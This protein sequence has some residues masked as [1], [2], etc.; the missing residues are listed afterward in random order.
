MDNKIN[1]IIE[2][3]KK[4]EYFPKVHLKISNEYLDI[5]KKTNDFKNYSKAIFNNRK[6]QNRFKKIIILESIKL[7][8]SILMIIAIF[9]GIP[10]IYK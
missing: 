9:V 1:N 8:T 3:Y 5:L 6:N 10:Y 4:N 2:Y 7:I